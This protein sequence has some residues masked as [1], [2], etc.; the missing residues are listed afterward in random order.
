M[1]DN[2]DGLMDVMLEVNS[3][4]AIYNHIFTHVTQIFHNYSF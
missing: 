1:Y 2:G 3:H 4:L